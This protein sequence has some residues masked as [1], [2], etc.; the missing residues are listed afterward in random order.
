M[1]RCHDKYVF[2]VLAA[3]I[4]SGLLGIEE[5]EPLHWPDM[6]YSIDEYKKTDVGF[7]GST[8]VKGTGMN[9]TCVEP[10]RPHRLPQCL[11]EALIDL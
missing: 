8:H 4:G 6:A 9:G 10:H 7:V 1:C 2:L 5:R 11:D 3:V